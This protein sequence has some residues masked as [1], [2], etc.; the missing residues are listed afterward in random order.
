MFTI[1]KNDADTQI[2]ID[3]TDENGPVDV[4]AVEAVAVVLVSPIGEETTR[5]A[6]AVLLSGSPVISYKTGY[7]D[8]IKRGRWLVKGWIKTSTGSWT[9]YRSIDV[10]V[11]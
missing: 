3:I 11:T 6:T 7:D 9:T 2:I 8:F 10:D 5:P 4:T 1:A